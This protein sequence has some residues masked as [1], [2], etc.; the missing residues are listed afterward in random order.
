M[1]KKKQ[2]Q[3][4]IQQGSLFE[5]DY[6]IRTL[7]AL[8]HNP[9]IALT[10]LVAN[11]WDAGATT[12]DITIPENYGGKLIVIDNGTG[13]TQEEFQN[14]WMKLGYN[15]LKHQGKNVIFPKGV[16]GKRFAYGRNGVGRHGLLCFNNEYTVITNSNGNKSTFIITTHS[17]TQP[18]VIKDYKFEKSTKGGT[19]LE[20]IVEK[21]LPKQEK[22]LN[23]ISARFLHDPKFIVS[24]NKQSVPLEQM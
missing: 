6:L 15:R 2:A 4:P 1:A 16:E 3:P 18:F 13:L 7:G 24:I 14:R 8:V 12:V 9:E 5:E 11:A 17:E 22:I 20:V 21:N 23:I 19:R 10:E